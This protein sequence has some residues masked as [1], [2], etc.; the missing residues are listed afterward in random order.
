M[1]KQ[2]II[3]TWILKYVIYLLKSGTVLR[4]WMFIDTFV[5]WEEISY[6][7]MEDFNSVSLIFPSTNSIVLI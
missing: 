4:V 6:S 1:T 7:I 2:I 3:K 5:G